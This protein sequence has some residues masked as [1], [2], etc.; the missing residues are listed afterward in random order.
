MY[1]YVYTYLPFKYLLTYYVPMYIPPNDLI[2]YL[3][4]TYS[5]FKMQFQWW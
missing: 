3:V 5:N 2:D 1:L 4:P